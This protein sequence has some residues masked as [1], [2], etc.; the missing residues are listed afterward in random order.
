MAPAPIP[1]DPTLIS[2][3]L[4]NSNKQPASACISNSRRFTTAFALSSIQTSLLQETA[5]STTEYNAPF[6]ESG[7]SRRRYGL[8][9]QKKKNMN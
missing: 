1:G 9:L 3:P 5:A 7:N 2:S 4:N 6:V 8:S